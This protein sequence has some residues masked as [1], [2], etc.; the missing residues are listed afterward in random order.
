MIQ[1]GDLVMIVR[2]DCDLS[3]R[4]VGGRIGKV[5]SI[6]S[7]PANIEPFCDGCGRR[8]SVSECTSVCGEFPPLSWLKKIPPLSELE[9]TT[10]R[11]EI[12]A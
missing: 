4:L 7:L 1:V 12:H 5:E 11:E 8:Y 6:G 10:H 9:E 2:P 3:A